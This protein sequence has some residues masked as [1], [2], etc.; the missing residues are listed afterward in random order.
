MGCLKTVAVT[1]VALA[2]SGALAHAADMP[3]YPPSTVTLP[4]PGYK[5]P[6]VQLS[7]GWY[8]RGDIGGTWGIISSANSA[9]SFADP[10]DNKLG[11]GMTGG[12]G[13]GIKGSWF[14]TDVT[15]DY[16][17]AMKYQ[18]TVV[19][20]N[21]TT[22]KIQPT[23]GLFN[24]Y[25]DLGTWYHMTPYI[26]AGAGVSYVRVSDFAGPNPPLNGAARSQWKFTWAGMAGVA[27]GISHNLMID[28]GYRYLNLGDVT[29]G[30]DALGATS[31]KNVAAHEAR[32]GLRWSFDDLRY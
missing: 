13:V 9:P 8:L 29:T 32:V 1:G 6:L 12:L 5:A 18:G 26:G 7:T 28:I 23:T 22:A 10:T 30:S 31:F 11:S 16:A 27:I 24:G 19:T 17:T 21:D 25:L 14:R 4:P 15:F 2:M 20:A 3:G